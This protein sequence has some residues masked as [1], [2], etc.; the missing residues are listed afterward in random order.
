MRTNRKSLIEQTR[1]VFVII[2]QLDSAVG[3]DEIKQDEIK[4]DETL[5]DEI[6]EDEI[7]KVEITTDEI[8]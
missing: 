5:K 7:L 2:F 4:S 1:S 8:K 3:I 6:K